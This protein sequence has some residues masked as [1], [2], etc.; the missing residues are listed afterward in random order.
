LLGC[1]DVADAC[2]LPPLETVI[3]SMSCAKV[4]VDSF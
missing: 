3:K 2:P 4:S 1:E